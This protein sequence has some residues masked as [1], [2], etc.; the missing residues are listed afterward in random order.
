MSSSIEYSNHTK[1][2]NEIVKFAAHRPHRSKPELQRIAGKPNEIKSMPRKTVTELTAQK[3]DQTGNALKEE[4]YR[5]CVK[6]STLPLTHS[7]RIYWQYNLNRLKTTTELYLYLFCLI[8]RIVRSLH[9][10]CFYLDLL[11]AV[12]RIYSTTL[13]LFFSIFL[14]CYTIHIHSIYVNTC[15]RMF[16]MLISHTVLYGQ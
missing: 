4:N 6:I 5:I 1:M 2:S 11:L 8:N 10:E 9:M 15:M 16:S 13:I 7:F 12:I 14:I 3:S